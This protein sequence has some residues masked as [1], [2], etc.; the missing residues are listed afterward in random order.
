MKDGRIACGRILVVLR[1]VWKELFVHKA[2]QTDNTCKQPRPGICIL[3]RG[4]VRAM[5]SMCF[6]IAWLVELES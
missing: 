3:W 4:L 5:I 1:D 2:L 6:A